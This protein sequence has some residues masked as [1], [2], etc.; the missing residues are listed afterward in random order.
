M[1]TFRD[2]I[3]R[4]C[5]ASRLPFVGAWWFPSGVTQTV[6]AGTIGKSSYPDL[7]VRHRQML[8]TRS[9][10]TVAIDWVTT[11]RRQMSHAHVPGEVR[12]V[13]LVVP[14]AGGVC[15]YDGGLMNK[16][17]DAVLQDA[18]DV[19][20]GVFIAPGLEGLPLT[21]PQIPGSAY[22]ASDDIGTVFRC[23]R[24]MYSDARINV[25]ALSMGGAVFAS[26][27][28]RNAAEAAS[29]CI[30]PAVV[31]A[32]GHTVEET[33]QSAD[34]HRLFGVTTMSEVVIS[35]W[36]R[37]MSKGGSLTTKVQA[38]AE[39]LGFDAQRLLCARSMAAW[40]TACLPLYGYKS[41]SE[42]RERVSSACFAD[43]M[44]PSLF[45]CAEDDPVCPASRLCGPLYDRPHIAVVKTRQGGHLGWIDGAPCRQDWITKL[46]LEFIVA[47]RGYSS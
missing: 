16:L 33:V 37:S 1:H 17:I 8:E 14:G 24:G 13:V 7:L 18:T 45:V 26:W 38:L 23:V 5:P 15:V 20:C 12:Q 44:I 19:T 21:S 34:A 6:V 9:G 41:V 35:K 46:V 28:A 29:L 25:V 31:L 47:C 2:F 10:G 27:C 3:I 32:Y 36:K 43:Y 11:R 42:M 22:C 30:G 40:D 39:V 4:S